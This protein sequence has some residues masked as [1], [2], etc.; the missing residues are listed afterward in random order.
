MQLS[1]HGKSSRVAMRAAKAVRMEQQRILPMQG[2]EQQRIL[3]M[4]G[5]EQQRILPVQPV[6]LG[7]ALGADGSPKPADLGSNP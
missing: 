7:R 1:Q 6:I 3:P 5:M 4:Q 2:M